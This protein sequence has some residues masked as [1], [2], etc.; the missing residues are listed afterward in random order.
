M[1]NIVKQVAGI[2]VAQDELV[3]SLGKMDI[4]IE[5][6]I[7]A[8]KTFAN[9]PSGFAALLVWISKHASAD[10]PVRFVMEA[11]GAY[12]EKLAYYLTEQEKQ[13]SIVL[14]SKISNYVKTLD[15]KTVTDKTASQA[16]CQFGLGRK[17][18]YGKSLKKYSGT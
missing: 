18:K 11:T 5:T 10:V 13:V 12:H 4:A 16:I 17:R 14:P 15:I 8:F 3:V 9:K 7:Y 1:T 2:D 6:T